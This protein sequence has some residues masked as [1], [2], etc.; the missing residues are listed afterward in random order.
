MSVPALHLRPAWASLKK[1]HQKIRRTHLRQL[2][3]EDRERGER[4]AAEA[5]GLYLDYSKNRITDE[6][7]RLLLQLAAGVGLARA[8][9]RHVPRREDQHLGEARGAA[10]RPARAARRLH[11]ASTARTS[12]PRSMPFSTRWPTSPIA[13]AAAPGRATPASASATSINIGIGG[14]DLGPGDGLRGAAGTTASASMTFRFVSNVDGTDFAEAVQRSRSRGDAVHRLLQDLHHARDDDQRAHRA[15]LAAGRPGR[16][17][18]RHRQA[19][20]RRLDQRRGGGE[21]RH[22]HRQHV[23]LLGLGRRALLDGFGHR[24]L[25]HAR[26]RA[27]QFPRHAGRLPR[28]G[29]AFP[30]R[31]VRAQPAGADGPARRLV[32]QLLRRPDRRRAALRAVPEA[33][34][35]LSP[36]AHHG[37][38]RQ[39]RDARRQS[40]S[41]T[42][43]GRSTGA[44]PAPTASTPSTS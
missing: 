28:D 30:H 20:R 29:R 26:H 36:A 17:A 14:S 10:R 6:T 43:P 33:L 8:H 11:P 9:R 41:T 38:Q 31:A 18:G 24:A 13:C 34:S 7:L 12:C 5:A 4:L 32:Q 27:G 25:D 15:R 44:S 21:V 2:F 16:R 22:R 19:L 39:A 37:E 1:H 35:R 40:R 3:A 42:T 23:R